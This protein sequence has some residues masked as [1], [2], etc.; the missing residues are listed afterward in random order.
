MAN[1]NATVAPR[2]AE[3]ARCLRII[4]NRWI[5]SRIPYVRDYKL[6]KDERRV[7]IIAV[8]SKAI[9]AIFWGSTHDECRSYFAKL[10]SVSSS[11]R[12]RRRSASRNKAHCHPIGSRRFGLPAHWPFTSRIGA[13]RRSGDRRDWRCDFARRKCEALQLRNFPAKIQARTHRP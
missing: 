3:Q 10:S 2:R 12:A 4:R 6:K 11:A 5:F 7:S 9:G 1:A 8:W 13:A